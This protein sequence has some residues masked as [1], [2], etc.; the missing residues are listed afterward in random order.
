MTSVGSYEAKTHLPRL[1]ERVMRGEKILITKHGRPVAML[2][3]SL[4]ESPKDVKQIVK[5]MLQFRDHEGPTLA[6]K[7]TIRELIEEG[8]RF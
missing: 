6:G 2:V 4:T 1:L 7:A 3:P 5:E 8:R